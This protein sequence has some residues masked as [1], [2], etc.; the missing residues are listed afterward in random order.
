MRRLIIALFTLAIVLMP[1]YSPSQVV[2]AQ[3]VTCSSFSSQAAAQA[4]YRADPVGLANLD[5][6]RD[7]IACESNRCPC[8]PTPVNRSSSPSQPA[9]PAATA[10]PRPAATATPRPAAAASVPDGWAMVTR[11]IDG[12]TVDVSL[13]PSGATERV[14][15]VGI[16]TPELSPRQC[17]ALESAATLQNWVQ[18]EWVWIERDFTQDDRDAYGRLLRYLWHEDPSFGWWDVGEWMIREGQARE[19]TFRIAYQ[20]QGL[21]RTAQAEARA[22]GAGLWGAC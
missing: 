17:Y 13:Y 8:D 5:A 7:G 2:D 22:N 3:R 1:V 11:V 14:R 20:R 18:G 6:D 16:N 15:I 12:D 19:Y 21:Y 9:Q 4:A 10:T